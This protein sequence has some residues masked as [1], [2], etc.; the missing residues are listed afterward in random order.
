MIFTLDLASQMTGL[1]LST[2]RRWLSLG[3][4][5][6][7]LRND[8]GE[9]Y[10]RWFSERD[11]IVIAVVAE[12]GRLGVPLQRRA[13]AVRCLQAVLERGAQPE[14]L[15]LAITEEKHV[16]VLDEQSP[17]R[18]SDAR[19]VIAVRD[20]MAP[21]QERIRRRQERVGLHGKIT[22][23]RGL[24]GGRPVLAGTRI[25]VEDMKHLIDAGFDYQWI[26]K[27]Y[28]GVSV[29]DL[30]AAARFDLNSRL[31]FTTH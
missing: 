4:V 25:P 31:A 14:Q 8:P 19:C 15:T 17:A 12:L 27:Q 23:T 28:P 24:Q 11:L 9:R 22:R 26:M 21:V 18:Q 29:L 5:E 6:P 7:S 13:A 2:L 1:P 3:I 16:K 30:D 20:A 10:G